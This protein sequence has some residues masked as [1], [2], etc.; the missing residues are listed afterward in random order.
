VNG[1]KKKGG[2]IPVNG[3][4]RSIYLLSNDQQ[5]ENAQTVPHHQMADKESSV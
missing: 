3:Y 5:K 2:G 4:T 1:R